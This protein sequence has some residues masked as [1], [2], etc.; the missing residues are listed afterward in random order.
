MFIRVLFSDDGSVL[1]VDGNLPYT[2]AASNG[3]VYENKIVFPLV[4]HDVPGPVRRIMSRRFSAQF[5]S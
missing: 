1:A 5:R 2:T 3:L 4:F